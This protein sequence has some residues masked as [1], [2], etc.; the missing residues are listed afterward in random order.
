[1]A[2][3]VV[4]LLSG[5]IIMVLTLVLAFSG[6]GLPTYYPRIDLDASPLTVVAELILITLVAIP[7]LAR[8]RGGGG[9]DG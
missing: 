7:A 3:D 8:G 2:P 5:I 1:M 9:T 6:D 4:T